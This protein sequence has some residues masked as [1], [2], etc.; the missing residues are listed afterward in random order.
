MGSI[1]REAIA[2]YCKLRKNPAEKSAYVQ[3]IEPVFYNIDK[4]SVPQ[5]SLTMLD[6]FCGAGGFSVG[7]SWAGFFPVLGIDYLKPAIETWKKNHPHSISCLG[8]GLNNNKSI[9]IH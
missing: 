3:E 2:S 5:D 7:C 4:L 1:G 9:K 6:L 8:D